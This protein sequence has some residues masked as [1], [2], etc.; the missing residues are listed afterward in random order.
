V[1]A[2]STT[3]DA[4]AGAPDPADPS[5]LGSTLA[6]RVADA[7]EPGEH[8]VWVDCPDPARCPTGLDA[9]LVA[10]LGFTL[11]GLVCLVDAWRVGLP[12]LG[13][14]SLAGIAV[15]LAV[16]IHIVHQLFAA[17]IAARWTVYAL[18]D[19]RV[20]VI[21]GH[22]APR[23]AAYTPRELCVP[24]LARRKD[25]SGTLVVAI[26]QRAGRPV[27]VAFVGIRDLDRVHALVRGLRDGPERERERDA[28]R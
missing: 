7:L 15:L 8:L 4:A 16:P 12:V 17:K 25:G 28:G 6:R 23:V 18:T 3:L 19:R 21:E 14:I 11:L 1:P 22:H 5:R 9:A 20:I 13:A 26:E 10:A 24:R 2:S 27:D